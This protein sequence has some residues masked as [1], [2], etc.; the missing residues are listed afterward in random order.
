MRKPI[1]G[2][3]S[4]HSDDY[5]QC[6]LNKAYI[7]AVTSAGGLAIV[8]PIISEQGIIGEYIDEIDGLLL[9]GGVDIDPLLYGENPLP[10]NG[11]LDPLRDYFELELLSYADQAELP[12]LGICKGCQILNVAMGGTLYQDLYK[13][14]K[15]VFKHFQDAPRWYP[16]HG[17]NIEG[18]SY[19]YKIINKKNTKVNSIHHQGIK[20][21][22]SDFNIT[23]QADDGVIEAIEKKDGRFVIGVQWHP[24]IMWENEKENFYLFTEF[25][26]Q[27]KN[28]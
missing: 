18:N 20:D 1:I 25:I 10:V 26:R 19:L 27:S 28:Q 9:T 15:T 14:K 12:I 6:K 7:E 5:T 17:I 2:I 21:V 13:Q 24:E 11:E 4:N 22:S 23:A 8:L 16:T 3:T